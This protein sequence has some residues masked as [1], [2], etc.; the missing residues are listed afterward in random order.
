MPSKKNQERVSVFFFLYC[1]FSF[2]CLF[3]GK[4]KICIEW[5][6]ECFPGIHVI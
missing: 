1:Q 5:K 6:M 3:K 2:T 4:D